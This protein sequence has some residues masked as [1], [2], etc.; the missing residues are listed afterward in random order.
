MTRRVGQHHGDLRR[1]LLDAALE[2]VGETEPS[3]ITLRA[4]ARRAGVSPAAPYHHF[5]DKAHLFAAVAAE[6][7]ASL[8]AVQARF[9]DLEP[10][11]RLREMTSE[12]VRFAVAHGTHYAVMFDRTPEGVEGLREAALGT[13]QTLVHAVGA[14]NPDL[15]EGERVQRALLAWSMAHGAVEVAAWVGEL[16]PQFTVE[17]LA[18]SVGEAALTTAADPP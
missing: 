6:G 14:V 4:V 8:A 2:L 15:D 1:A 16:H 5:P 10:R 11:E 12:Y 17:S 13:F 3:A 9:A 18:R 7:F